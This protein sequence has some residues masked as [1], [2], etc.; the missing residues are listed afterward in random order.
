MREELK[1]LQPFRHLEDP[2]LATVER[3]SRLSRLPAG[4]WL[5][6]GG[7]HVT[8]AML[9]VGGVVPPHCLDLDAVPAGCG[10]HRWRRCPANLPSPCAVPIRRA[11]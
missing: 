3:H 2:A 1:T 4:R 10:E 9:L 8:R 7:Q 11:A 6:R 5:M